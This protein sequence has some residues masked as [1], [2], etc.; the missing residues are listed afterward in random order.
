MRWSVLVVLTVACSAWPVKQRDIAGTYVMNRGRAAD[1]LTLEANGFY[2]RAYAVPGQSAKVETGSWKI[3][4]VHNEVHVSLPGFWPWWLAETEAGALRR[5]P[6]LLSPIA[7]SPRPE[8]TWTGRLQFVV[9]EGLG[10]AY[11]QR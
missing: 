6:T 7:F 9:D 10:W 8:R 4:T 3:D 5:R 11:V 1:T 2:R